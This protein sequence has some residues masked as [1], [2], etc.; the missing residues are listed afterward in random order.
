[1]LDHLVIVVPDLDRARAFY[2]LTLSPLGYDVLHE[3]PGV[4]ALGVGAQA[5]LWL[6]QADP[7]H[8][9]HP[10]LHLAFRARTREQV[11]V[12]H[13]AGLA[14]GGRDNGPPGLRED[15]HPHYY[16]AFLLDPFGH[17]IEAVCHQA[18]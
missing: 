7:H 12:F 17:N 6:G 9:A 1:M 4:V 15:N 8:P 10:P 14:A 16:A 18:E 5:D 11:E 3:Y 13:E 2:E